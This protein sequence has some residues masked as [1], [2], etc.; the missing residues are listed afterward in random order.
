M[1]KSN[2]YVSSIFHFIPALQVLIV[3]L[4]V[5]NDASR[6]NIAANMALI[7]VS[8]IL[9][10]L[11]MVHFMSENKV[12][13]LQ[14]FQIDSSREDIMV[15]KIEQSKFHSKIE[16]AKED[17]NVSYQEFLNLYFSCFMHQ[18][19]QQMLLLLNWGTSL[20]VILYL[21]Y[22]LIGVDIHDGIAVLSMFTL[23]LVSL[24]SVTTYFYALYLKTKIE[25]QII[26]DYV[27]KHHL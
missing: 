5:A 27:H 3:L 12:K 15:K 21:L 2:K 13:Q 9:A 14:T 18:P 25:A 22:P 19:T 23:L 20:F 8:L 10:A 16:E 11:N 24:F 26:E 4:H 17:D 6:T 7:G 1:I